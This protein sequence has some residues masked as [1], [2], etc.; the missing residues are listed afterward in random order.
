MAAAQAVVTRKYARVLAPT[1]PTPAPPPSRVTP[2]AR[3]AN[4]SGTMAMNNRLRN[5]S[6][7]GLATFRTAHASRAVRSGSSAAR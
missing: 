7:T 4:T 6:P 2:T 5:T 1:R 3:L